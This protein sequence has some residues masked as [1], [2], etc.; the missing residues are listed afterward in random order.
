MFFQIVSY[1]LNPNLIIILSLTKFYIAQQRANCTT[2][3]SKG[4]TLTKSVSMT[5]IILIYTE[6]WRSNRKI[7][8]Y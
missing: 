1:N 2:A 4:V 8:L 5:T 6:D 3:L 7:A